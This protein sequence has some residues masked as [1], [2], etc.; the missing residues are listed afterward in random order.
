MKRSDD[1]SKRFRNLHDVL[2]CDIRTE[3]MREQQKPIFTLIIHQLGQGRSMRSIALLPFPVK[4]E[5]Q[6][7]V[8]L[9]ITQE[10][11]SYI[12][13]KAGEQNTPLL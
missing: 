7:D 4:A 2:H 9:Y 1:S 12:H 11:S 6:H 10:T 3:T 8:R 13:L 5:R